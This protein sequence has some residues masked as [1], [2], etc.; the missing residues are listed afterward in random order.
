[1]SAQARYNQADQAELIESLRIARNNVVRIEGEVRDN[2]EE[3]K[4]LTGELAKARKNLYELIDELS[5]GSSK[6][7]IVN[8]IKKEEE[9][10]A[11]NNQPQPATEAM[12]AAQASK[13][14]APITFSFAPAETDTPDDGPFNNKE[15]IIF[16]RGEE[17]RHV[18]SEQVEQK[19]IGKG[20]D[21]YATME[22]LFDGALEAI[23][24]LSAEQLIEFY[25]SLPIHYEIVLAMPDDDQISNDIGYVFNRGPETRYLTEEILNKLA[26]EGISPEELENLDHGDLGLQYLSKLPFYSQNQLEAVWQQLPAPE[27]SAVVESFF[28]A[29]DAQPAPTNEYLTG[30]FT[31]SHLADGRVKMTYKKEEKYLKAEKVADIEESYDCTFEDVPESA[32][33]T[34]W[35]KVAKPLKQSKKNKSDRPA[36]A[37]EVREVS[38]MHAPE[39]KKVI[40]RSDKDL[41]FISFATADKIEKG[42]GLILVDSK[43]QDILV[44]GQLAS[45]HLDQMIALWNSVFA[46]P[47][48]PPDNVIG[49]DKAKL[50]R[51]KKQPE[52]SV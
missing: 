18:S 36:I 29:V 35:E 46:Q 27:V 14:N 1:M 48:T 37:E 12:A 33:E 17:E 10:L 8:H 38:F 45:L 9:K 11:N 2:S 42:D 20:A 44:K 23:K 51:S 26:S 41:K 21:G 19:L 40:L 52:A 13:N 47:Y 25:E 4:Q 3:K 50:R 15:L 39:E 6:L 30:K 16:V 5:S 22:L 34:L 31:I 49:I 28:Q 32:L 43:D 7:P 24:A